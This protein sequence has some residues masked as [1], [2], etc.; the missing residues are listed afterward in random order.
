MAILSRI[1]VILSIMWSLTA[2]AFMA[3]E[4]YKFMAS[5]KDTVETK[6]E[7]ETDKGAS[8]DVE[9][10]PL[11]RCN[12]HQPVRTLP[13]RVESPVGSTSV[14]SILIVPCLGQRRELANVLTSYLSADA[15][16]PALYADAVASAVDGKGYY[17]VLFAISY[18]FGVNFMADV[19]GNL[20][21][22]CLDHAKVSVD[23]QMRLDLFKS[24]VNKDV[25]F[26]DANP[27]G[28]LTSQVMYD[29]KAVS[30]AV[31]HDLVAIFQNVFF[32][33]TSLVF[34]F[35]WSWRMT[36]LAI[37][38][39]PLLL[40][41]TEV[42]RS[43]IEK[44]YE[45]MQTEREKTYQ[46]VSDVLSTMKTVRSFACERYEIKR[47][48]RGVD[49]RLQFQRKI[50]GITILNNLACNVTFGVDHVALLLYG[51]HLILSGNPS[52]ICLFEKKSRHNL[53]SYESLCLTA[54]EIGIVFIVFG[55]RFGYIAFFQ[56]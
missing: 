27:S 31:S 41:F 8:P 32:I 38:T 50:S 9:Y 26:F 51:G 37:V 2:T 14:S 30:H 29:C 10:N 45:P 33:L 43:V 19:F 54:L 23:Y 52:L 25:A 17:D 49:K 40:I 36:L 16:I 47:F 11:V 56:T 20:S 34:T 53:T 12:D 3:Y 13:Q 18:Y 7:E 35:H 28:E 5:H 4:V 21:Y 46:V 48:A 55:Q 24:L 42:S 44:H 1:G 39:K 22:I 15:L 6:G